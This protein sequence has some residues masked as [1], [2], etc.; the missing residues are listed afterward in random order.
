M[1]PELMG[2]GYQHNESRKKELRKI[3]EYRELVDQVNEEVRSGSLSFELLQKSSKLLQINPEYY[4]IWNYRRRILRTLF[5]VPHGDSQSGDT[6]GTGLENHENI[7]TLISDDLSFLLPLLR[8]YP[9][10]YWIWNYRSWL[11]NESTRLLPTSAS[12]KLWYQE[13]G[14]DSRMLSLDSRNF[15]GWG[16]RRNIVKALESKELGLQTKSATM[17]EPEFH[18]TT[19]MIESNLS[20]FSAWHHRSKLIPRLLDERKADHDA[21][22][23]ML[24]SE[25]ELIERA[26]YTDPADQSLWFYHQNLMCTFDPL[27]AGSSMAPDLTKDERLHYLSNQ[28]EGLLEMLDGA[29]DCK[30]IY[31]S[32]LQLCVV[33]KDNSGTWPN[34]KQEMPK[35]VEELRKLDPLRAGRWTDLKRNLAF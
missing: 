19:K 12:Q 20:N 18:Y 33:H 5:S 28:I 3:E 35:W 22:L 34:Q 16:Y 25:L 24:D 17:T 30:W 27:Y 29:E 10:C 14:L 21:R 23:K 1:A 32:L 6:G 2:L 8:Q 9:K 13:L 31:Q 7:E 11:L 26:L 15:H 4:T